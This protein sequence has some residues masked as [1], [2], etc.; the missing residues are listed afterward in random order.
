VEEYYID[1]MGLRVQRQRLDLPTV[2]VALGIRPLTKFT[3]C[4]RGVCG[5]KF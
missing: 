3:I 4:Y 2:P 1:Q 5:G